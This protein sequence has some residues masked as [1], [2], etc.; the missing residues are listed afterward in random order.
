MQQS[1]GDRGGTLAA[2]WSCHPGSETCAALVLWDREHVP[3]CSWKSCPSR[4]ACTSPACTSSICK[5]GRCPCF[6]DQETWPRGPGTGLA[7]PGSLSGTQTPFLSALCRLLLVAAQLLELTLQQT[8]QRRRSP[9]LTELQGFG[10]GPGRCLA[11]PSLLHQSGWSQGVGQCDFLGCPS[12]GP[13]LYI[14]MTPYL[15]EDDGPTAAHSRPYGKCPQHLLGHVPAV[16]CQA[17]P[18]TSPSRSRRPGLCRRKVALQLTRE[19]PRCGPAGTL[20]REPQGC[21]HCWAEGPPVNVSSAAYGV[22]PRT[23]GHTVVSVC[24]GT[25]HR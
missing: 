21:H 5:G 14:S 12:H 11:S 9:P 3:G 2:A 17:S 16:L 13:P 1:S 18:G 15:E 4:S 7:A 24:R 22:H 10:K 20:R 6:M 25:W 8:G 23:N 19:Q